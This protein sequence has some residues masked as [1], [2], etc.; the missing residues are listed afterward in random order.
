MIR[1]LVVI[2][3]SAGGLNALCTL[4]GTLPADYGSALVVVQHRSRESVELCEVLQECSALPVQE[5]V[6][7]DALEPGRV[8]LAPADYHLLVEE[9]HL[10]LSTDAPQLYSRPSIDVAM[11]SAAR[12]HGARVVGVVLT[13]ANH[14]GARGLRTIVDHGG[15]ALVQDPASAEVPRMPEAARAAV[16]EATVLPL[17]AIAPY[18]KVL[19]RGEAAP[20]S[21]RPA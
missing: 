9:D 18:L 10:A 4:L 20:H 5:V 1:R 21:G 17:V 3:V 15:T 13:G 19:D 16:P 14:D 6:D 7:K 11:E 12:S 8:Y 2:G